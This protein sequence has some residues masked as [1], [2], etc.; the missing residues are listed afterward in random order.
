MSEG[1]KPLLRGLKRS[2]ICKANKFED[3]KDTEKN[4]DVKNI[5]YWFHSFIL[6]SDVSILKKLLKFCTGFSNV[7]SFDSDTVVQLYR[8]PSK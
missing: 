5:V 7:S 1:L 3:K 2:N 8:F 6:T 4:T